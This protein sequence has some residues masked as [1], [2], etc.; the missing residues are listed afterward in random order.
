MSF[1]PTL[2]LLVALAS[3]AAS[4]AEPVGATG[5]G[6][7]SG[8][9]QASASDVPA[10]ALKGAGSVGTAGAPASPDSRFTVGELL[11]SDDFSGD[12]GRWRPE[13]ESGGIVAVRDGALE[14][15]VPGGCSVWFALPLEGPLLITYE[16]TA[17]SAGGP[18]DRVSDLNCFWMANDTRSPGDLLATPRSGKFADYDQ[19]RCYYVGLGGN[20]NTTTRFRRYI[21]ERGNRPLLPEHDLSAKEFLLGPNA[22]Q[23]IQLVAAGDTIGYY[24]D[25]RR[26]FAYEDPAPYMRGWFALRTVASHFEI[27]HFRVH[28]L[29]AAASSTSGRK[30]TSNNGQVTRG[31]ESSED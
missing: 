17:V 9:A 4:L 26:L 7:T 3:V 1:L 22:R 8:A 5:V 11:A 24:R 18:N 14:I 29:V 23:T 19:L 30:G 25:G 16:A 20:G 12:L 6:I 15:D 31:G 28:R 21:G 2:S 10:A 13:L 27:R